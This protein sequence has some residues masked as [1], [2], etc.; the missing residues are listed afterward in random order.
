VMALTKSVRLNKLFTE[1][2][3]GSY[4]PVKWHSLKLQWLQVMLVR[5]V[6]NMTGLALL[7]LLM[8]LK[9]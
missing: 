7:L 5:G 1:Q 4:L 3:P 9:S 8:V 2:Y 6:F